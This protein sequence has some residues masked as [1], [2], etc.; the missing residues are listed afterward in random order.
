MVISI[1]SYKHAA[2][3]DSKEENAEIWPALT[4]MGLVGTDTEP[5]FADK[6]QW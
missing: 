5:A 2:T 4:C 1:F 6:P 3:S